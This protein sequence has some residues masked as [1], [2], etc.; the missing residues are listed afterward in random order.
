MLNSALPALPV[1]LLLI[2]CICTSTDLIHT[3][4]SL[5][6]H[7]MPAIFTYIFKKIPGMLTLN[8]YWIHN[9]QKR[10]A[11]FCFQVAYVLY[12]CSCTAKFFFLKIQSR[13]LSAMRLISFCCCCC[14]VKFHYKETKMEGLCTHACNSCINALHKCS[15]TTR[16]FHGNDWRIGQDYHS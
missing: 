2:A 14:T 6:P 13:K 3:F 7:H 1:L 16:T 4:A 15:Q 10:Q 9:L 8:N 12:F 5:I 11:I